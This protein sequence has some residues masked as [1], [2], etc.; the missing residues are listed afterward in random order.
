MNNRDGMKLFTKYNRINL[1]LTVI[2]FIAG[3][4]SFSLLIRYVINNQID[5]DLITEKDEITDYVAQYGQLP[6]I[7]ETRGEYTTYKLVNSAFPPKVR[8]YTQKRWNADEHDKEP[9]RSV[10]WSMQ[11]GNKYYRIIVSK[12]MDVTEDLIQSIVIITIVLILLILITGLLIN[13]ILFKKLWQ[14]FYHSMQMIKEFKLHDTTQIRLEKS[15][16]EEFDLMNTTLQNALNKAQND[17]Y[18]LKEFT[19]NASHELQTPLAIISSKLD[20]I[21]QSE[22]LK[23]S[24]SKAIAGAYEAIQTLKKLNQSLLLLAKIEN[25]QFTEQTDINLVKLIHEKQGQF[26][27]QLQS[28]N[29]EIR[30]SLSAVILSGNVQ[31]I[32]ILLNNLFSNAIRY[33]QKGGFIALYSDRLQFKISNSGKSQALDEKYIFKRFYREISN[34][35]HHGLGLSIVKQICDVSGYNCYYQ[36]QSPNIHSF[37]VDWS[38]MQ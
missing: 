17:Y 24:Q 36:F 16:I 22:D 7:E 10:E 13:R 21:I 1:I 31:L 9:V 23:E 14:P 4:I 19:E 11:V 38:K 30:T 37:V 20:V 26:A 12:S 35:V 33:N 25:R 3:S 15:N 28:K 18:V 29:I 6:E 32:D 27:E 8:F 2:I 34:D 5:G